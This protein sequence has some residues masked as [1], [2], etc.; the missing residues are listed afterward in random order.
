M[1][2]LIATDNFPPQVGGTGAVFSNLAKCLPSEIAILSS[3]R[4]RSGLPCP[5]WRPLDGQQP[6]A[7]HRI[8]RLFAPARNQWPA[9]VRIA[10]SLV[11]DIGFLRAVAALRVWKI[12]NEVQPDVF[13][14]GTLPTTYWLASLVRAWRNIPVVL[15]AHGEEISGRVSS[16]LYD[17][18]RIKAM[19]R[20]D[21][22]IAV[23]SNTRNALV[24]AGVSAERVRIVTK[25]VDTAKFSPG[26]RTEAILNRHNLHGKRL[27]LTL[28]RLDERKGQDMLIRAMPRILAAVPNAAY[29]VAGSGERFSHLKEE[30]RNC[31]VQDSVVFMGLI[32]EGDLANVYRTCDVFAMPNRQ[33][34]NGDTEGF[35]L[36]FLE[37]GACAKPVIGGLAGGVPDAIDSGKTGFLVDG[38]SPSQIADAAIR[39]LNNPELCAKL[40]EN[41]LAKAK[42]NTWEIKAQ[43]FRQLCESLLS[44][45]GESD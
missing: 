31:G 4:D 28:A 15:Y 21:L 37:A 7:V 20:A 11:I 40:G 22:A 1:R 42:A 3:K 30:A 6:F 38:T 17:P 34:A 29:L 8:E 43:E 5:G 12:L 25:G 45:A 41:G 23:S 44:R 18:G 10:A 36:V 2:I 33:L 39:L 26:P 27:L 9:P 13:C 14:V 32:P 16:R 19:R 35:G 24:S